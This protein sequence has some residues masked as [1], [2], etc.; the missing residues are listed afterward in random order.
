MADDDEPDRI[1]RD[2]VA[3][4]VYVEAYDDGSIGVDKAALGR[5]VENKID[6]KVSQWTC[7]CVTQLLAGLALMLMVGGFGVWGYFNQGAIQEIGGITPVGKPVTPAWAGK[8]T[9]SC[10]GNDSITVSGV[11][12]NLP[13]QVVVKASSNCEIVLTN[14]NL[15]GGV[16][17]EAS[18]NASVTMTGG[19]LAGTDKAVDAA[20]NAEV[21]L[22]KVKTSGERASRANAEIQER[23]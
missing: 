2:H 3:P 7:G 22:Q 16:G 8:S 21:I 18:G 6:Q 17:I 15:S 14:C 5:R 9:L 4:G 10:S 11:T 12:A 19:S 20:G 23:N 1:W 13:G